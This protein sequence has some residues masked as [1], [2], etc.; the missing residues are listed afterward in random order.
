MQ[1]LTCVAVAMVLGLL[2]GMPA[3]AQPW[4]YP[5]IPSPQR[6]KAT[7]LGVSTSRLSPSLNEQLRLPRGVGLMVDR[8]DRDSPAEAA[9]LRRND[10]LW[11]LD[12]QVLINSQQL[13]ILVRTFKSGDEVGLTVIRRGEPQKLRAKLTEREVFALPD[14]LHFD[15]PELGLPQDFP[16][17]PAPKPFKFIPLPDGTL[18]IMGQRDDLDAFLNDSQYL[19]HLRQR[20]NS[21]YLTVNDL[22]GRRVYDGPVNTDEQRKELPQSVLQRMERIEAELPAMPQEGK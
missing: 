19:M 20:K 18:S 5:Q 4:P 8:I 14:D 10:V 11:K 15:V 2:A 1:R 16:L 6:E 3:N 9:G 13:R 22:F 12:D 21:R 17:L 7:Y